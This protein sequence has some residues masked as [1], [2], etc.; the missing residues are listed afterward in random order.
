MASA[1]GGREESVAP[2]VGGSDGGPSIPG[3]GSV[4]GAGR[5]MSTYGGGGC[6]G[7]M[8]RMVGS[9]RSGRSPRSEAGK[10]S[11]IFIRTDPGARPPITT[12]GAGSTRATMAGTF[13]RP[14]AV[15]ASGFTSLAIGGRCSM[16][17]SNAASTSGAADSGFRACG[18]NPGRAR[19]RTSTSTARPSTLGTVSRSTASISSAVIDRRSGSISSPRSTAL[20]RR[21]GRSGRSTSSGTMLGSAIAR[22][23]SI[24]GSAPRW[25]AFRRAS[26]SHR[27]SDAAY[28][29]ARTV[30]CSPLTCSGAMYPY[31]PLMKPACVSPWTPATLAMPKSASFTCP[32]HGMS[33]F[34][35]FTSR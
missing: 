5:S 13:P 12:C 27:S 19:V 31:V 30:T 22:S 15:R 20:L 7:E 10:R 24:S 28:T 35:G 29:S 1:G 16:M 3:G 34:D 9:R 18:L 25:I 23:T 33:T 21:S 6:T 32:S 26:S 8:P 11:S 4:A 14:S 2:N 17:A